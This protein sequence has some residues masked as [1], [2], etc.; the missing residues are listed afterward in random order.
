MQ[1]YV[2][3]FPN[4][5]SFNKTFYYLPPYIRSVKMFGLDWINA[6]ATIYAYEAQYHHPNL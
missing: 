2:F 3:K 4:L 5:S 1:P 6:T